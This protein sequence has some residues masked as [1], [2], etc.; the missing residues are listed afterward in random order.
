MFCLVKITPLVI[1]DYCICTTMGKLYAVRTGCPAI[2]PGCHFVL[3]DFK[4]RMA[5]LPRPY[6]GSFLTWISV[7]LP[8]F[9][10]TKVT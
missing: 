7:M 5:S 3:S 4:T 2:I 10:I 8:S 9:S 1:F 6:P